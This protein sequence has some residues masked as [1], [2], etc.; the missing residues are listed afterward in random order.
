[1]PSDSQEIRFTYIYKDVVDDYS[2]HK[3][4]VQ[5]VSINPEFEG[6]K[7]KAIF[8]AYTKNKI[9]NFK[10]DEK[11]LRVHIIKPENASESRNFQ[12]EKSLNYQSAF[13]NNVARSVA[14]I[15]NSNMS[16]PLVSSSSTERPTP[17][18]NSTIDTEKRE[19]DLLEDLNT[20]YLNLMVKFKGLQTTN[21]EL[22]SK[23]Q[24]FQSSNLI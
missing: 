24:E 3:F 17:N 15:D 2:S 8:D 21:K 11:G 13:N 16:I 23:I 14:E 6:Q 12:N 7:S 5:A 20:E 10:S 22:N 4:K 9:K 1:M 18:I 19:K